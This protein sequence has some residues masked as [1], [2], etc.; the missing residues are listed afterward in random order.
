MHGHQLL[1]L[2][3]LRVALRVALHLVLVS[4][5]RLPLCR[6][7]APTPSLAGTFRFRT[8]RRTVF[9][10]GL[11]GSCTQCWNTAKWVCLKVR[12]ARYVRRRWRSVCLCTVSLCRCV[13]VSL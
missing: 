8:I 9:S 11:C 4:G 5:R 6:D 3:L 1:L 13:S 10:W 7:C 2:L 12:R